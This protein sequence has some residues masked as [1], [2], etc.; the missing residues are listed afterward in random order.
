[1]IQRNYKLIF[2]LILIIVNIYLT[3][4]SPYKKL[5]VKNVSNIEMKNYNMLAPNCSLDPKE[6]EFSFKSGQ[7]RLKFRNLLDKLY[8]DTSY[9]RDLHR[10]KCQDIR[11]IGGKREIIEKLPD[12]LYRVEGAWFV[13]FDKGVAPVINKCT[14]LS[15]GIN[16]DETFDNE[17]NSVYQ[18]RV[19]SLDPYVESKFF[20]DIRIK[21]SNVD[22]KFLFSKVININR[23]WR[24]H[25]MGI[26]G[27]RKPSNIRDLGL[28]N[29]L[30]T[31]LKKVSLRN[32]VIDVLK[33][34]IELAEWD[35]IDS[36]DMNYICKYVKQFAIETHT[37]NINPNKLNTTSLEPLSLLRKLEKC[38]SL[39]HRD[40][41]LFK[42]FIN[43][44]Y[45]FQKT[46]FQYPRRYKLPLD[47]FNSE[48]ELI[49]HLITYGELYFVNENFLTN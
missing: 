40:T 26:Y 33:M 30:D 11:R 49:N 41:R 27:K 15:I 2:I 19:E 6:V 29:S 24:Y 14:V 43:G 5:K 23:K 12:K 20:R 10:Y 37:F 21:R 4:L 25:K 48:I 44:P 45:G 18:C 16:H 39:F 42:E 38:F 7:D 9:P 8:N 35:V 1:M 32:K 31:I 13:C 34:D 22:S 3:F 28:L 36:L 47:L 46:E 17:M